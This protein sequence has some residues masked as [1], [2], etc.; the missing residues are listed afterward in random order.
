MPESVARESL[1]SILDRKGISTLPAV[2]EGRT[3]GVWH[4]FYNSPYNVLAI[5]AFGTWFYPD[6]FKDVDPKSTMDSLYKE[7]LA[8]EPSGTYWIAPKAETN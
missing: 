5:Q 3:Y 4:S 8:I 2:K 7:F 6:R 1:L